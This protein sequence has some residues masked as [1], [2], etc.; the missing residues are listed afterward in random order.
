MLKKLG[1][2]ADIAGNGNEVLTALESRSYDL[3]LM[4]IQMPEMDGLQ[5]TRIMRK[6][7]PRGPR[8]V[9]ITACNTYGETCIK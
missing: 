6:R 9:F 7:W 1:H 4:D 8:I 3:V 2:D 5:A